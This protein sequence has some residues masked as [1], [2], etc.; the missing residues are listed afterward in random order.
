MESRPTTH[1]KRHQDYTPPLRRE[2]PMRVTGLKVAGAVCNRE[3]HVTNTH[4]PPEKEESG[5]MT[6]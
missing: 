6:L 2:N 1:I 4:S 3:S 5:T